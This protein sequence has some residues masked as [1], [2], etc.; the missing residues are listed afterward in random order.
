MASSLT[1]FDGLS[2]RVDLEAP[3][4]I[5]LGFFDWNSDP[6]QDANVIIDSISPSSGLSYTSV[7]AVPGETGNYSVTLTPHTPTAFTIRFLATGTNVEPAIGVFVIVVNDVSTNF[8]IYGPP[9][10]EVSLSEFYNTTFRYELLNGTGIENAEIDVVYSGPIGTL[11]WSLPSEHGLGNYSLEFSATL[12]GTYVITIIAFKPFHD[13]ASSSFSLIVRNVPTHLMLTG[14]GSNEMGL[15]ETYELT[16]HYEMFNGTGIDGASVSVVH[17]SGITHKVVPLVLG[18]YLVQFNAT[19]PGGYLVTISASRQYCESNSTSFLLI[20]REISTHLL[21]SVGASEDMGL[22]DTYEMNFRYE[23][24]NGTGIDGATIN[25]YHESNITSLITPLG[26]GN[27]SLQINATSSGPYLITLD[28]SAQYCQRLSASFLLTVRSITTNFASLNG[29]GDF[30]GFGKDYRLFVEYTNGT[31][32][33]LAGATV[34]IAEHDIGITYGPTQVEAPGIY[35]IL[36]TP[37]ASGSLAVV[38]EASLANHQTR[39]VFFTLTVTA[40]PSTLTSLNVSTS[41]SVDQNFT[42]YLRYQDEDLNDLE[43]ATIGILN[44][45]QNLTYSLFEDLGSGIYRIT[46]SPENKGTYDIVFSASKAGYQTDYTGFTLSAII[47]QTGLSIAGGLSSKTIKYSEQ[48]ELVVLYTRVDTGQNITDASIRLTSGSGLNWTST[49]ETSGGYR[50]ILDPQEAGEWTIYIYTVRDNY[51]E[52]QVIFHL[53]AERISMIVD[54]VSGSSAVEGNPFDLTIKLSE[55]G[56][57]TPVD[58]AIVEYRFSVLRTG[59]FKEMQPTGNPGEY[60]VRLSVP[61][62]TNPQY[63]LEIKVEKENYVLLQPYDSEFTITQNFIERNSLTIRATGGFGIS[64]VV[65]FVALR[66]VSRRRKKQL[67]I[68][69]SNKKRFDDADN[70]I[71]VIV[72]HKNSGIPIYSRIVKG[73]FEE[74]I[75]AAFISAVT[76]F[77]EEFEALDEEAMQVIPIS[78]IIRAVQTRNLICAFI[79]IRSASIEHNRKMEAFAQQVATYLDD[80]YTESR[81]TAALDSRI[82]EILDYVYDETMDGNLIKFYKAADDKEFPRRYRILERLLEEIETRHCSRPVYLAQGVATFGVS[83]ARGCTLVLEAIDKGLIEQCEEHEP[84]VED[85]EFKTFFKKTNNSAS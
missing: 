58:G 83:E 81:P 23:M 79:T 5:K 9:S 19:I 78:D 3:K 61:L 70:I 71:G 69:I 82:S 16:F 22:T 80:F 2:S 37:L 52:S 7:N 74:G 26:N 48:Y 31:N 77:R 17:P 41:I 54:L 44:P 66:I 13:R 11:S 15:N 10:T 38:V 84:T 42:V 39:Q 20:V 4:A 45:P 56:S 1:I 57:G 49:E 28:A 46:L 85:I 59:E 18:D 34:T 76:H 35:S 68:D 75:V 62:Y 25:V 8:E 50:I 21:L 65:F 32:Y 60:T 63:R 72:M 43:N 55:Y 51:E 24:Y 27:Y 73:G 29:T 6:V 36:L 30:V 47:I 14:G 67:D 33:G 12:P 40:I 53:E 64:L